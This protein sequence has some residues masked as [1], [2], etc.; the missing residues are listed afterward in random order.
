MNFKSGFI[1][2][3]GNANVGKSTL[4]NQILKQK[5]SIVS[6]KPQTTRNTIMGILNNENYQIVF[7]DTPG[8]HKIKNKLDSFMETSINKALEGVDGVLFL[9]DSG[10][11]FFEEQL[12]K[13]E[14]IAKTVPTIV[15]VNKIDEVGVDIL[16]EKLTKLNQ[17]KNVTEIVP[18]SAKTG[19]NVDELIACILKILPEGIP[20]YPTDEVTDSTERF[21]VSEIIREKALWLLNQEIPHGIAVLVENF[22]EEEKITKIEVTIYCEK[23]NHKSII[24]GK[25][26]DMLKKIAEK[27]RIELEKLLNKKIFLSVWVKVDKKWRSNDIQTKN[28]GYDKKIL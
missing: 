5:V 23:Q 7:L 20:L 11:P 18:I 10:K 6:P 14:Q 26:G 13:I 3:T 17:L 9:L 19:K 1:A 25:N 8:M 15:A 16:F 22:T 24:I 4:L 2:I 27:S 28:F 12:N 21:L